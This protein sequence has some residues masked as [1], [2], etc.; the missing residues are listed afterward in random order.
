[1]LENSCLALLFLIFK[2]LE[3][4]HSSRHS[5][6][7]QS[8]RNLR[9]KS[10]PQLRLFRSIN[11]TSM[12]GLMLCNLIL[13]LSHLLNMNSPNELNVYLVLT[14]LP[15]SFESSVI[16]SY[17]SAAGLSL[18]WL[19][20]SPRSHYPIL[21]HGSTSCISLTDASLFFSIKFLSFSL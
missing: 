10:S 2:Y 13:I 15:L 14:Y 6:S 4:L 3:F 9:L 21:T 18:S 12:Q 17:I 5:Q 8:L 1:M 7:S 20:R 19:S 11:W 16:Q